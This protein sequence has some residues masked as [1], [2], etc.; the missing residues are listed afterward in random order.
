MCVTRNCIL[1][2]H[3]H[4]PTGLIP[5]PSFSHATTP[6]QAGPLFL[7]SPGEGKPFVIQPP[8]PS[9]LLASDQNA[10]TRVLPGPRP[11]LRR[12]PSVPL[13]RGVSVALTRSGSETPSLVSRSCS[14]ACCP[15]HMFPTHLHPVCPATS[16]MCP[17]PSSKPSTRG[18]LDGA[19]TLH[20]PP[21][22]VL[23][24]WSVS[25]A[26]QSVTFPEAILQVPQLLEM[27]CSVTLHLTLYICNGETGTRLD[28]QFN[29][30][31]VAKS[32]VELVKYRFL[33]PTSKR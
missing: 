1:C 12:V 16:G 25:P 33:G 13:T 20:G 10:V 27:T 4:S 22:P 28:Q 3:A 14:R 32:P 17:Q 31:Y 24:V 18:P 30:S 19:P 7:F 5:F 23:S 9:P 2:K 29:S 26:Q 21:R 6:A 8:F 15:Q 11:C